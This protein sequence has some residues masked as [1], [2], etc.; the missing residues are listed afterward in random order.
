MGGGVHQPRI[1]KGG[2]CPPE[3]REQPGGALLRAAGHGWAQHMVKR[4][5]TSLSPLTASV[6]M[7]TGTPTLLALCFSKS[8]NSCN[9]TS[10]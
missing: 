6:H 9:P 2:W 5:G 7:L 3:A 4:V 10:K 8:F 1:A